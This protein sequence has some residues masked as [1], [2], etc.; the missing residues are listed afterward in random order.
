VGTAFHGAGREDIDALM[1]GTGRPFVIEIKEPKVRTLDLA[2]LQKE[3]NESAAGKI[4]VSELQFVKGAVVER[5]KSLEAE[6]VYEAKV[7]F[8]EPITPEQLQD[9]LT[10]LRGATIEQRTP[11]RVAHRRAD[12]V[13]TRRVLEISGDL[14]SPT[15]A[16]I[17]VHCEGG[18]YIKELVSGDGGR[19]RP[20]LSELLS[21]QAEV[22]ELNVLEVRGD[23]LQ[24]PS[25]GSTSP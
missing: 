8:A 13:R 16:T 5:L 11:T 9:A 18:L 25:P 1:L 19:T 24:D 6:K 4:E 14:I 21:T 22:T 12:L 20:S 17:R 10:R 7:R 2:R 3:I 15:E 23:F